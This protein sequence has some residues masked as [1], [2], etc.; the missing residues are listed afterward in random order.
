MGERDVLRERITNYLSTGGLFNA[1]MAQHDVVR[2]LLIDCRKALLAAHD[3]KVRT[4]VLEEVAQHVPISYRR[5][6]NIFWI[7]CECGW[8]KGGA[9]TTGISP[10]PTKWAEHIRAITL[11]PTGP[12]KSEQEEMK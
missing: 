3:Q 2:D 10:S 7:E 6:W 11:S 4:E 5:E 8:N 12:S 9:V 1:E